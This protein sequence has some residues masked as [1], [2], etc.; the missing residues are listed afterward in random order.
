MMQTTWHN[1]VAPLGGFSTVSLVCR[2]LSIIDDY[3]YYSVADY[4]RNNRTAQSKHSTRCSIVNDCLN[5][6]SNYPD[7]SKWRDPE[8]VMRC[9]LFILTMRAGTISVCPTQQLLFLFARLIGTVVCCV[10]CCVCRC[11]WCGNFN[12]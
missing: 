11:S 8:Q 9:F 12:K 4:S 10:C 7:C 2:L 3:C 1:K 5:Y 6:R